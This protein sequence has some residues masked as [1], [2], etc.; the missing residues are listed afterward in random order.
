MFP[1]HD[2]IPSRSQPIVNWLVMVAN[3]VIFLF[4]FG[5]GSSTERLVYDLGL[6]PA[7]FLADPLS[8]QAATLFSSM[9]LHGGWL[10]LLF[11][12]WA[13]WIFGDNV[14]DRLGHGRYLL[15]YLF[16]GLAAAGAHLIFNAGSQIPTVGASG[17]ISAVMAAYLLL[18][19]RAR[20]VTLVPLFFLPWFVEIPALVYIVFWFLSQLFNGVLSVSAGAEA[21]GGVAWWAHIGGFVAGLVMLPLLARRRPGGG[22]RTGDLLPR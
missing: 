20:V 16:G 21:F 3:V 7:R 12:M 14:E 6:V 10:H 19:P 8:G 5:A 11:N 15:F 22:V 1:L 17:A 2:N 9:F 18:F 4:V 13:L